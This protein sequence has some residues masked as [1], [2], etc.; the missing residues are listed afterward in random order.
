[1]Y[2]PNT[3]A[4][5]RIIE[6]VNATF[7]DIRVIQELSNAWLELSPTVTSVLN[8][9]ENSTMDAI[10]NFENCTKLVLAL[11]KVLERIQR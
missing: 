7:Q 4:F 6:K 2:A 1:M 11:E 8:R 3:P 5:S 10:E 9:L